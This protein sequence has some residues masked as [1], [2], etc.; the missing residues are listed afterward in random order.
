MNTPQI[1][2][3]K[4]YDPEMLTMGN[5]GEK[6]ICVYYPVKDVKD[7]FTKLKI[8]TPKLRI[9]F[10]GDL[11]K[12]KEGKIFV[13]NIQ[14]S[15]DEIGSNNNKKNINTFRTK[16]EDT[17][18]KIKKLLPP[19]FTNK[20]ISNSLWQGKNTKY[21]PN[22]R[23]SIPFK[24]EICQAEVYDS[25]DTLLDYNEVKKGITAS[26]ILQLDN[27]WVTHDKVGINWVA[28]QFKIYDNPK[29]QSY[30]RI[31]EE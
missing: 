25:D 16:I 1:L 9:P 11:R 26:V 27:I 14:L 5:I 30:F 21:S 22:M 2:L 18:N 24:D 13:K 17:D 28:K 19:E 6:S 31:R 7:Q 15:T 23:I 20:T 4:E 3:T 10:D 12:T 29:I 8:Q